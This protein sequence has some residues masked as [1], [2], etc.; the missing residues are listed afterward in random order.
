MRDSLPSDHQTVIG[1]PYIPR[2]AI[3]DLRYRETCTEAGNIMTYLHV[4]VF[5]RTLVG[6]L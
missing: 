5:S 3:V 4:I 2:H 1:L 6:I